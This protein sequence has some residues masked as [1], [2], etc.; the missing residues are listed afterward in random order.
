MNKNKSPH[1]VT[2]HLTFL[3]FHSITSVYMSKLHVSKLLANTIPPYSNS[4]SVFFI[5][6]SYGYASLKNL[7]VFVKNI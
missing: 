2:L 7:I 3:Y 1:V 6:I 4:C 5:C